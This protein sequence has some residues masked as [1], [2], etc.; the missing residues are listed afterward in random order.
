MTPP[1]RPPGPQEPGFR[2]T[3]AALASYTACKAPRRSAPASGSIYSCP[4]ENSATPC[5]LP[6][7]AAPR[8]RW[9]IEAAEYVP[10]ALRDPHARFRYAF[11][12]ARA[13]LSALYATSRRNRSNKGPP[14]SRSSCPDITSKYNR[15][16]SPASKPRLDRHLR[17]PR[18][19]AVAG[20]ALLRGWPPRRALRR[21]TN[22][23]GQRVRSRRSSSSTIY[24]RAGFD[25][26]RRKTTHRQV[27]GIHRDVSQS[28]LRVRLTPRPDARRSRRR[29][30]E[31]DSG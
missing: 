6:P 30:P 2:E 3:A 23:D 18:C 12:P 20:T 1:R 26:T 21:S 24:H 25:R 31:E 28:L 22:P 11:S 17:P 9:V 4:L 29:F 15:I 14:R 13:S 10:L 19:R 7:P 16:I 27:L 5:L 8:S